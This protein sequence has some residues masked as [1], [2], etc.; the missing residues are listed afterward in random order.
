MPAW[1][2]WLVLAGALAV[3]EVFTMTF[4]LVMFAGGAA[5]AALTAALG[6]PP[7]AQVVVALGASLGL[8]ALVRPVARR[9]LL[10]GPASATGS[11]ALVGKQAVVMQ[12]VD[13]HDGRVRL[14][15]AEWSARSFDDSQVITAGQIVR[16]MQITGA[17]AVVWQE[18]E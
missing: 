6:G 7:V 17:T 16:V 14:N 18:P 1:L 5:G 12:R 10:S 13:R 11:E 15:G 4:V 9:H 3:A 8:L 2:I